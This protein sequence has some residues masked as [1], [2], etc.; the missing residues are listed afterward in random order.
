[1]KCNASETS[2]KYDGFAYDL[3]TAATISLNWADGVNYT[4]NCMQKDQV[5]SAL[6]KGDNATCY[7]AIGAITVDSELVNQGVLYSWPFYQGG[8]RILTTS[9]SGTGGIFSFFNT[10]T[11]QLW[12]LIAGTAIV[13]PLVGWLAEGVVWGAERHTTLD[14][15][16]YRGMEGLGSMIWH[17]STFFVSFEPLDF[18]VIANRVIAIVWGFDLVVIIALYTANTAAQVSLVTVNHRVDSLEQLKGQAVG[19]TAEYAPILRNL[20]LAP[21]IFTLDTPEDEQKV[22]DDLLVG[23]YSAVILDQAYIDY[24]SSNDTTCTLKAVGP[25]FN[26]VN[27]AF[28]FPKGTD[29]EVIEKW[30]YL[31]T[32]LQ[33]RLFIIDKLIQRWVDLPTAC[34]ETGEIDTDQ[35]QVQLDQVGGLWIIL[36][37]A[38]AL[39]I[40]WGTVLLIRERRMRRTMLEL[41]DQVAEGLSETTQNITKTFKKP[42]KQQ[43]T[44]TKLFSRKQSD[45]TDISD[46]DKD[47][48]VVSTPRSTNGGLT[49]VQQRNVV[50]SQSLTSQIE[51]LEA[52][53][54][55]LKAKV[56]QADGLYIYQPPAVMK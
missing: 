27:Y 24:T 40:V 39:A 35:L 31:L 16:T 42:K 5:I 30:D 36:A 14:P 45:A 11:W 52:S 51:A 12:V 56:G 22:K 44:L 1:M 41:R 3:F 37:G 21:S 10:F 7:M 54:A 20:S 53:L 34:R 38:V 23:A 33:G 9:S 26:S 18:R 4:I 19:T 28:A 15:P 55:E 50:A 17:Y 2:D 13:V 43:S 32:D 46:F 49:H 6:L 25:V 29:P 8:L 47:S 48:T